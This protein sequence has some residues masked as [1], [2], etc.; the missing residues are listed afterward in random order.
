MPNAPGRRCSKCRTGIVRKGKC[1][2]C[3]QDRQDNYNSHTRGNSNALYGAD[4]KRARD[5]KLR[6][7]PLCEPCERRGRVVAANQVHHVRGFRGVND[8][9]RLDTRNLES[10]C[11]ECHKA[12]TM[13]G[14]GK[15]QAR[16]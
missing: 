6:A 4:W 2:K 3:G 1:N 15:S 13:S 12:L 11:E 8:P 9:L 10:I 14:Q 5:C 16:R 7:N